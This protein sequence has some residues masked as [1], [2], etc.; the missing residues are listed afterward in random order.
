MPF[1][2]QK[3]VSDQLE[4]ENKEHKHETTSFYASSLGYCKRKQIYKR[5]NTQETNPADDRGLRV[6]SVGNLFHEWLTSIV[7]RS[8]TKIQ[9]EVEVENKQY[10]VKGRI[11]AIIEKDG[12]KLVYE[13]KSINS[14][15]FNYLKEPK[16][17]NVKQLISYL[18]LTKNK[19]GRLIY[20]SKDDAR[21][22]EFPI[23]LTDK[24][25]KE[26]KDELKELNY[27]MEKNILP[28]KLSGKNWQCG[29]CNYKNLC[30]R[31]EN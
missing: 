19:E 3:I 20:L 16:P 14:K 30:Q 7:E 26:V 6:F 2:I 15:G 10:N 22:V 13:I 12:E 1:S 24:L 11:D 17:E 29:Y 4:K 18:W 5:C 27:Y 9:E 25:L 8:G 23:R 21:I 31:S 28:K